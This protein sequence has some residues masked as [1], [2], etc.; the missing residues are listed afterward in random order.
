ML[1]FCV[2]GVG[3]VRR[4]APLRWSAPQASGST[5]ETVR[6]NPCVPHLPCARSHVRGHKNDQDLVLPPVAHSPGERRVNK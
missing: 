1:A 2:P 5:P 6:L 4:N 3:V